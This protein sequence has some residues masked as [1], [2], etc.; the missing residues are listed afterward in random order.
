MNLRRT[1]CALC[2]STLALAGCSTTYVP[3]PGPRVAVVIQEGR[4]GFLREGKFYSGGGL[5]GG[6]ID[7]AVRGNPEAESH[8]NAYRAGMIGGFA[9]VMAGLASTIGGGILFFGNSRG[10]DNRD[11]TAQAAGGVLLLGG[12]AAYVTGA[13]L[14]SNA[15]PHLWDA[16][17][18]YNDGVYDPGAPPRP[19]GPYAP[20]PVWQNAPPAPSSSGTNPPLPP[21]AATAPT[22]R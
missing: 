2:G 21:P 6:D 3:R 14:Q 12:L 19:Y 1:I 7:E 5:F 4:P 17:N 16:I 11:P 9:A 18:I 20:P 15:Q 13:I 8:A 22:F 10:D